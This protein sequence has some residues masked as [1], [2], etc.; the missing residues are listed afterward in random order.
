MMR[1][2]SLWDLK[3]WKEG[4]RRMRVR[5]YANGMGGERRWIREAGGFPVKKRKK[6]KKKKRDRGVERE[7]SSDI[8]NKKGWVGE[9]FFFFF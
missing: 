8:G 5:R 1:A 3:Q 2:R 9:D 7:G 4:A 6:E